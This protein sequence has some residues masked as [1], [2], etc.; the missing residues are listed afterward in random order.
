MLSI[1]LIPFH[2]PVLEIIERNSWLILWF[3]SL[4][5]IVG[6]S[7]YVGPSEGEIDTSFLTNQPCAPPCWHGIKLN[8][9]TKGDVYQIL[10]QLPFIQEGSVREI[11]GVWKD[12]DQARVVVFRCLNAGN[13]RCGSI[14]ISENRVRQ[15]LFSVGY[16]LTLE[17]VVQNLG[18]PDYVNYVPGSGHIVS[19]TLSLYWEDD[20]IHIWNYE[21]KACPT[22]EEQRNGIGVQ[23]EREA[24]VNSISYGFRRG[25]PWT[26]VDAGGSYLLWP[27]FAD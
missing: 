10:E 1:K 21:R 18:Y 16:E 12:D 14:L 4:I 13:D 5:L 11:G 9:S 25:G 2:K 3:L 24:R 7:L 23:V 19:C 22:S 26:L 20:E 6:C 15:I 8:E 17:S 27:G